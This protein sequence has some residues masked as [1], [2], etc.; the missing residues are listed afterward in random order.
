[1]TIILMMMTIARQQTLS[2]SRAV[3]STLPPL[4]L[5]TH[6]KE[7][8]NDHNDEDGGDD[9]DGHHNDDDGNVKCT[10][11][12]DTSPSPKGSEPKP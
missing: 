12:A 9:D 2:E 6:T 11:C 1:M 3:W 7:H 10:S 8:H 4:T 5:L